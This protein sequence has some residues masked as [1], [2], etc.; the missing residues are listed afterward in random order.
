MTI[1]NPQEY[2]EYPI[3]EFH[4]NPL[5]EA[6][7]PLPMDDEEI[8]RRVSKVPKFDEKE[9]SLSPMFRNLLPR[10]LE[11][12][13]YFPMSQ[14]VNIMRALYSQLFYGYIE[15]NPL[16]RDGQELLH[17]TGEVDCSEQNRTSTIS[18]ITG[19]S[20]IGKTA[21]IKAFNESL[22]RSV[23]IH[24]NYKG[25]PFTEKQIV[26]LRHNAPDQCSP[27]SLCETFGNAID[28]MLGNQESKLIFAQ[29]QNRT[30]HVI[31]LRKMLKSKHVG[32]LIIDAFE[33]ISLARAGGKA[34]LAAMFGNMRDGLGVPVLLAGTYKAEDILKRNLSTARRFTEGGYYE[35]ENPSSPDAEDWD[36]FCK[37]AWKYQ[38]VRKSKKFS[39]AIRGVLFDLSQG[40]T[41][42]MLSIFIKAQIEAINT[43]TEKVDEKMLKYVYRTQMQP[44]HDMI[45]AL[46][47]KDKKAMARYEDLYRE[48][49]KGLKCD[50]TSN[51]YDELKGQVDQGQ[52]KSGETETIQKPKPIRK[53]RS[54]KRTVKELKKMVH[55]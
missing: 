33:N 6:L 40:I 50:N 24:N 45:N 27:K 21:L 51:R 13:F 14:Q 19:K 53:P 11:R 8:I 12:D 26:Y 49:A 36:V 54:T 41:G 25:V 52:G 5:I 17:N 47:S 37:I 18:F 46:R 20:G 7:R 29:S 15:R 10:R 3:A 30:S 38:W 16:T 22:G 35:L 43:G 31:G 48:A 42:I 55:G 1:V 44:I 4:G 28:T 34:E 9:L 39:D 32:L 23:I 2:F